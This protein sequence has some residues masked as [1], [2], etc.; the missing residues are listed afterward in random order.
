MRRTMLIGLSYVV[1]ILLVACTSVAEAPS[2]QEEPTP[3]QEMVMQSTAVDELAPEATD[4]SAPAAPTE[5]PTAEAQ[6]TETPASQP[7][8]PATAA[9]QPTPT[10]TMAPEIN[11]EYEDTFYRGLA[12]API[13]MIDYSDFL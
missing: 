9:A 1:S 6:E 7:A 4:T 5:T 3:T 10:A 2:G 12:T 11:G 13:T 8:E